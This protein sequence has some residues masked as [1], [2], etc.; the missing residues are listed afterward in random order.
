MLKPAAPEPPTALEG[1]RHVYICALFTH[2]LPWDNSGVLS[3]VV[4]HGERADKVHD[5]KRLYLTL[6]IPE[7]YC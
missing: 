4:K 1:G 7:K 5:R 2:L 6:R 3:D